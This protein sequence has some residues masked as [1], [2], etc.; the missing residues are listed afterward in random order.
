M[1]ARTK[2]Q[3]TVARVNEQI[4]P[5]TPQAKQ[6]A[7]NTQV[8]HIAFRTASKQC[9]CGDCAGRFTY[10]GKAKNIRCPH[11]GRK[12]QVTD[13]LKR[14]FEVANYFSTLETQDD[15]QVQRVFTLSIGLS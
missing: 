8:K 4:I 2:F 9:T 3:K 10:E 13:T 11:C 7:V 1:E 6:W 15:M 12:L 14:K 5:I